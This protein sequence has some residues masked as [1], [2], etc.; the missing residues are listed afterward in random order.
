MV[1]FL[2]PDDA[3][4]WNNAVSACNLKLSACDVGFSACDLELTD[5]D[6]TAERM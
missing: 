1:W 2:Q 5:C 6:L 3:R 4:T